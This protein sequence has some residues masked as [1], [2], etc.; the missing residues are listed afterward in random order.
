MQSSEIKPTEFYAEQNKELAQDFKL[1]R[2]F[3]RDIN[4][5]QAMYEQKLFSLQELLDC[6]ES[7]EPE[8]IRLIKAPN[9]IGWHS[10]VL[11]LTVGIGL[12]LL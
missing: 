12:K 1:S 10:I 8:L 6:F 11:S 4:D 9:Y 7:L 5:V 2:G 3:D